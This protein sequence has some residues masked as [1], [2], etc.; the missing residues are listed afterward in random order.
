MDNNSK[1]RPVAI[2]RLGSGNFQFRSI[3]QVLEHHKQET[4]R[5]KLIIKEEPRCVEKYENPY[6]SMC[7]EESEKINHHQ[8]DECSCLV[9]I[10][11]I[12]HKENRQEQ[13]KDID[14]KTEVETIIQEFK[15]D[16]NVNQLDTS[17]KKLSYKQFL[18]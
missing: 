11:I 8:S 2:N 6:K 18:L 17:L 12:Y 9:E 7:K 15:E 5:E 10:P 1:F 14:V 16:R 3:K 13:V 4:E